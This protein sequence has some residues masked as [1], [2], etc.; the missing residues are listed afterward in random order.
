VSTPHH[1]HSS[2]YYIQDRS[3]EDELLRLVAQDQMMTASMNGVLAEQADPSRLRRVLDVACGTG[4]WLIQLA[5]EY[6]YMQCEGIDISGKMLEY[7]REQATLHQVHERVQFHVMDALRMLEFP[8]NYFDL[9]NLRFG[10]SFVR[11]WEWA[12]MLQEM[13][14]VCKP[15][16]I[17]RISDV[18]SISST[19]PT[20]DYIML[21]IGL[22]AAIRAGYAFGEAPDATPKNLAHLL[23]EY[24]FQEIRQVDYPVEYHAGTPQHRLFVEDMRRMLR[25][26]PAFWGKWASVPA[27]YPTYYERALREIEQA[28]FVAT[29][30]LFTLHAQA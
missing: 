25:L 16:G 13:R 26:A 1:E 29:W 30:P 15:E 17:V 10:I 21:Q 11:T 24:R 8:N 4:G 2:T 20:L 18:T 5:R 19:S 3:N 28:D 27:D 23:S 6:P 14:R 12:K 9:V 7:A 22:P